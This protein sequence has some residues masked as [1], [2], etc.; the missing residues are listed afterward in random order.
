MSGRDELYREGGVA[1]DFVFSEPVAEVFDDMLDRSVPF[2][3]EVIAMTAGLLASRLQQS[4]LVCD[5]GCATGATLLVLARDLEALDLRLV[6]VDN[7]PAMLDK[8]RRR[9][10][11]YGQAARINFQEADISSFEAQQAGAVICNYTLQFLRPM[12]REPLLR[13]IWQSL[14]PGGVLI[15]SEKVICHDPRLNRDFIGLHHGFKKSRGYSELEIARKREALEN[16]LVPF[17]IPENLELVEKTGFSSVE[18]FF[19]W[20]NFASFVAVK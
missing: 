1:S 6:G 7:S 14:R 18:S 9:A 19:Q 10:A 8:A 20:F 3:R 13:R 15:L 12:Q 11:S 17:S 2:Y 5:L 16:V 4:D